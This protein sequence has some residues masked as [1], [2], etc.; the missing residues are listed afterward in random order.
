M[1]TKR[2]KI[3][4][5]KMNSIHLKEKEYKSIF[6]LFNYLRKPTVVK[7]FIIL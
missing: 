4:M 2:M 1:K 7:L 5:I 6:R 3:V